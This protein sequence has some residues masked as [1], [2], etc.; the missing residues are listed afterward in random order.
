MKT[1]K[2]EIFHIRGTNPTEQEVRT[3]LAAQ[4]YNEWFLMKI[5]REESG[6]TIV[7]QA[8]KQFNPGTNYGTAWTSAVGCPNMG[9]PSGFGLM[10]LDNFGTANGNLL[11]AT[12]NQIWNWKTNINRGVQFLKDDK[13]QCGGVTQFLT[14]GEIKLKSMVN[15]KT[16]EVIPF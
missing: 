10:Q 5:I 3:Y 4:S 12:P 15:L 6:S 9:Y 2:S 13:I 1:T 8:M 14:I 11:V 16:G 7:G